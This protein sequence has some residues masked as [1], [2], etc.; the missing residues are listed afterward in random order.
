MIVVIVPILIT[1]SNASSAF[2]QHSVS[3]CRSLNFGSD[4]SG[5]MAARYALSSAAIPA[6]HH[7]SDH[8]VHDYRGGDHHAN[9]DGALGGT[10]SGDL[11]AIQTTDSNDR[12]DANRNGV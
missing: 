7:V 12:R 11:Y 10:R 3:A 6:L 9:H 1:L 4:R 5:R 8:T 2:T